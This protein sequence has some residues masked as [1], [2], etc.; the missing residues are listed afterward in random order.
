MD[1]RLY[2][3]FMWELRSYY[4]ASIFKLDSVSLVALVCQPIEM[5]VTIEA[6]YLN[7]FIQIGVAKY[8][9]EEFENVLLAVTDSMGRKG[10]C[11]DNT[12]AGRF[13]G[14]LKIEHT[15]HETY[16]NIRATRIC[17]F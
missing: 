16:K 10:N 8:V 14:A 1:T 5:L 6:V 17:L 2:D 13:F 11:W 9:S 4:I 7:C 12:V 3:S 15:N